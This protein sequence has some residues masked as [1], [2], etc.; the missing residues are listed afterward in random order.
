ML[1]NISLIFTSIS[2]ALYSSKRSRTTPSGSSTVTGLR[3]G[4]RIGPRVSS[5]IEYIQTDFIL[6]IFDV[7]DVF[8]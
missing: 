1:N 8:R 4:M 6:W 2:K 7:A 5:K 3:F